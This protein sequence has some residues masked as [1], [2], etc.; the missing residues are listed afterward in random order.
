[1]NLF[2][3]SVCVLGW[4]ALFCFRFYKICWNGWT[5]LWYEV[6]RFSKY[7]PNLYIH[8]VLNIYKTHTHTHTSCNNKH[9]IY[10]RK[11]CRNIPRRY[12]VKDV[13]G[14]IKS[15]SI[16]CKLVYEP[17]IYNLISPVEYRPCIPYIYT[18]WKIIIFNLISYINGLVICFRVL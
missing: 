3:L 17:R 6:W 8:L 18:I 4:L 10:F 16:H 14:F 5:L 7:I 13:Y 11:Q 9:K 2:T 12:E 15:N 1:M